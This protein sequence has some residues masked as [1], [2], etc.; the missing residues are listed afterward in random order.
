MV[1]ARDNPAHFVVL[2][3]IFEKDGKWVTAECQE[4]GTTAFGRNLDEAEKR[5]REAILLH[6]NTLEDVGERARFFREH[7]IKIY[8]QYPEAAHPTIPTQVLS[9]THVLTVDREFAFA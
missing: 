6:L 3:C 1:A 7:K 8:T 9:K 4:L 5:L 2:T